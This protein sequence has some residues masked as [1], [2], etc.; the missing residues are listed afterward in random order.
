MELNMQFLIYFANYYILYGKTVGL[1]K[2]R[3]SY[4]DFSEYGEHT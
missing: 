3:S 2:N 1:P 4:P